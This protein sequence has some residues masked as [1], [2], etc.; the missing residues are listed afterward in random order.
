MYFVQTRNT[1]IPKQI[2]KPG[3]QNLNVWNMTP[4]QNKRESVA[5]AYVT[6]TIFAKKETT[7]FSRL[8]AGYNTG[9]CK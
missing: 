6:L 8:N 2:P 3:K 7:V 5:Y 9:N 1:K 4:R